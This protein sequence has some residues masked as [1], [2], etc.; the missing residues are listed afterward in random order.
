MLWAALTPSRGYSHMRK[1]ARNGR[2]R[3]VGDWLNPKYP[4]ALF[5]AAREWD[6]SLK[7]E[8]W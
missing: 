3:A 6:L 2:A 1:P 4:K 8:K 5:T 7:G